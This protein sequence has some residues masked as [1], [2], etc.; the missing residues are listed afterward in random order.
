MK[1]TSKITVEVPVELREKAQQAS[2]M[3]IAETICTG[4]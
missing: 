3:I 2:G 1:A 4:P